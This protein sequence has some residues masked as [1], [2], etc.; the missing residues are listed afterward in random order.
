VDEKTSRSKVQQK[1]VERGVQK[2][3]SNNKTSWKRKRESCK[4]D[5]TSVKEGR[6]EEGHCGVSGAGR[7][8]IDRKRTGES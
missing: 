4:P 3:W 1:K 5:P 8:P 2:R 7:T 6:G